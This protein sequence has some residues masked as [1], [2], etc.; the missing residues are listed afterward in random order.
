MVCVDVGGEKM[1]SGGAFG[2]LQ[3]QQPLLLLSFVQ[4][5]PQRRLLTFLWIVCECMCGLVRVLHVF[6]LLW[7]VCTYVCADACMCVCLCTC[8]CECMCV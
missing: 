2:G 4:Q 1:E 7:S 3:S 8:V 6:A 5:L